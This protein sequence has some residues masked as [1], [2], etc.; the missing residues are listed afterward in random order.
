MMTTGLLGV[1][2]IT[3]RYDKFLFVD[4]KIWNQTPQLRNAASAKPNH[5]VELRSIN[6]KDNGTFDITY[7]DYGSEKTINLTSGQVSSALY[8]IINAKKLNKSKSD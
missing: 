1:I 3:W 7:W 5:F 2:Y 4:S 6:K 8:G